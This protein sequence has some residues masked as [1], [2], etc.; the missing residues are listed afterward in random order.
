MFKLFEVREGKFTV[1]PD[2]NSK[3]VWGSILA[4]IIV[5][6]VVSISGWLKMDEKEI[7][8]FYNLIIQ[9]FGLEQNSPVI[10]DQK[11]LEAE[12][13]NEVDKAIR[14]YELLTGDYGTPRIPLPRL[15][16]KAPD[17][18]LC[19]SEDCQSLGGEMRLCAPWVEDCILKD[20]K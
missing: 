3:T 11:K 19:Y 16:E 15:I 9:H 1:L 2:I 7:W 13:E 20:D 10:N 4:A 8:K 5:T 14:E 12:I 17:K 6:I 18:A